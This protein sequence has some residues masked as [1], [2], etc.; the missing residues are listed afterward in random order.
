[1]LPVLNIIL[2]LYKVFSP[3]ILNL[4]QVKSPICFDNSRQYTIDRKQ[5]LE[6]YKPKVKSGFSGF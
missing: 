3:Q 4:S 1:M 2:S 6:F 5:T